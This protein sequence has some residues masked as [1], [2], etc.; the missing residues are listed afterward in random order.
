MAEKP[1]RE[2][3]L[4]KVAR[5]LSAGTQRARGQIKGGAGPGRGEGGGQAGGAGRFFVKPAPRGG[6]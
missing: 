6:V 1:A 3:H 5:N 2:V 4:L